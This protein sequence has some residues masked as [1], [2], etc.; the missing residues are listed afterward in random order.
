MAITA[1][2]CNSYKKEILDGVHE[3]ADTYKIALYTS[4]ATLSKATT[5]PMA[6]SV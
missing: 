3:A 6:R 5:A 1:A 2:L 4:S